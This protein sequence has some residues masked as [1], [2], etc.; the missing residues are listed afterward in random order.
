[1]GI[2]RRGAVRTVRVIKKGGFGFDAVAIR[3]MWTFKF[4]PAR[5]REGV[6][7]DF[8]ITYRYVF[9]APR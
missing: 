4:K 1:V 5:T 8:L 2:D 7:V 9:R 3:G 6:P